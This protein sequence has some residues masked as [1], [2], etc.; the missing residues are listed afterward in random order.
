MQSLP[1][2]QAIIRALNWTCKTFHFNAPFSDNFLK[3]RVCV[4]CVCYPHFLPATSCNVQHQVLRDEREL[5]RRQD[6]VQ[7]QILLMF[8]LVDLLH[9]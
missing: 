9:K 5:L 7:G 2:L 8:T 1:V 4:C 6:G 3:C